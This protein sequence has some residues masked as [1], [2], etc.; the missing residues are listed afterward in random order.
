MRILLKKANVIHVDTESISKNDVLIE[1]GLIKC[2]RP[3]IMDCPSDT[4]IIDCENKW[5]LPGLIDMHVHIKESFAHL[6][7]AAGVTT[8]RNMAGSIFELEDMMNADN[9][10]KTPRVISA[11]RMIDGPPGLWGPTSPYNFNTDDTEIARNEVRR[12]VQLGADLIKVYGWLKPNVMEAV[13]DE[14]RMA[15]KVVSCDLIYSSEV[16]AVE[17]AKIGVSWNEHASGILQ[18]LHPE[19]SMQADDVNWDRIDWNNFNFEN[20]EQICEEL[21][22]YDVKICPTITIYDQAYLGDNAWRINHIVTDK[23]EENIGLLNQWQNILKSGQVEKKFGIQHKL[24]K[25]IAKTYHSLGG[26]VVCG[27]DTPAGIFTYPGMALHRELELFVESGFTEF[28]AIKAAT[29]ISADALNRKDLGR[30]NEGTIA[31]LVILNSNPIELISNSKDIFFIVKG[32]AIYTPHEL[33][34]AVPTEK[35]NQENIEILISKFKS[36]DLPVDMLLN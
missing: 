7:T 17:A 1:D 11:D 33:I 2:I 22:K 9:A 6:F 34:K 3:S 14:A 19:W 16:N 21:F 4:Q 31:D 35:E 28:E 27:T 5:I 36:N 32:G 15:N 18:M 23:V 30:I 26:T 25:I 13:C 24:I 12:Q 10:A 20:I 8:V 29:I